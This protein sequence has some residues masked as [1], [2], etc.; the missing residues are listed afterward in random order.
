MT[1]RM[2]FNLLWALVIAWAGA[3]VWGG[4]TGMEQNKQRADD[5]AKRGGEVIKRWQDERGFFCAVV[6]ELK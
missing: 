2:K 1:R 3:V 4:V 6:K 5:C